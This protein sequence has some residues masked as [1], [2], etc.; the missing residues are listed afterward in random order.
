VIYLYQ[1]NVF[2]LIYLPKQYLEAHFFCEGGGPAKYSLRN[3]VIVNN[4]YYIYVT[5]KV[6]NL[7]NIDNRYD[8]MKYDKT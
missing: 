2:K 7:G 6:Y 3:A 1:I 8:L 5:G 4:N